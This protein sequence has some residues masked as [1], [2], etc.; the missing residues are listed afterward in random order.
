MKAVNDDDK[1]NNDNILRGPDDIGTLTVYTIIIISTSVSLDFMALYK[2]CYYYYHHHLQ[3]QKKQ[4]YKHSI[5]TS[6][7]N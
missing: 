7:S 6:N 4:L 2:C 1:Y 5:V 3:Q